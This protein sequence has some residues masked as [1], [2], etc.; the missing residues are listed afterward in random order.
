MG[1]ALP[2]GKAPLERAGRYL[3]DGEILQDAVHHV[4]L[5]EVLEF[6]D[7]VDHVLA[8]GGPVDAVDEPA[9]LQPRVLRL[10]GGD[11]R[12][13]SCPTGAETPRGT[14]ARAGGGRLGHGGDGLSA[15]PMG[16]ARTRVS[17]TQLWGF[18]HPQECTETPVKTP[19]PQ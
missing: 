7:E 18:L 3:Q 14:W 4:L 11:S 2:V 12:V 6:V 15:P 10:R 19:G 13:S 8:H 5:R 17:Y 9:V 16:Q 1:T